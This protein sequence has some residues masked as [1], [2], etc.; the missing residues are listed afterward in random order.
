MA[1]VAECAYDARGRLRRPAEPDISR[2]RMGLDLEAGHAPTFCRGRVHIFTAT[3]SGLTP[4]HAGTRANEKLARFVGL[5]SAVPG[6]RRI[7]MTRT[8]GIVPCNGNTVIAYEI[9]YGVEERRRV[10]GRGPS[11]DAGREPG[12]RLSAFVPSVR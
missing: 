2:A 6:Y 4:E 3:A 12:G 9:L 1:V 7:A 5:A 11:S 8:Q 10:R